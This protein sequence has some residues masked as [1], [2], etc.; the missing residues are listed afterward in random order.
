MMA[1]FPVALGLGAGSE[2]R[3]PMAVAVIGGLI[4]ST[5]LSLVVVP[6]FYFVADKARNRLLARKWRATERQLPASRRPPR[7]ETV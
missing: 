2:V 6:C 4:V 7:P 3:Q 1:A 5:V